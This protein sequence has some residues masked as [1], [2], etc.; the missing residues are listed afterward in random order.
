[1]CDWEFP[2]TLLYIYMSEQMEF[3]PLDTTKLENRHY[4]Q[5]LL[6][7][8]NR[9][10]KCEHWRLIDH[11]FP[12]W[13]NEYMHEFYH[14]NYRY[15]IERTYISEQPGLCQNNCKKKE[16]PHLFNELHEVVE[17][18]ELVIREIKEL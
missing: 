11:D 2:I 1:M 17:F 15:E 16:E 14:V 3:R 7:E 9:I 13:D 10:N 6:N 12:N 5:K 18:L 4:V 8:I